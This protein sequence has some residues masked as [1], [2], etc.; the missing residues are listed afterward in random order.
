VQR[1]IQ[2]VSNILVGKT[3]IKDQAKTPVNNPPPTKTEFSERVWL[4]FYS[5]FDR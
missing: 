2:E 4:Y 5:P 3:K 1:K